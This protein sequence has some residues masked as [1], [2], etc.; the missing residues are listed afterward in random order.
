[1]KICIITCYNQPDYVRAKTLRA[2]AALIDDVEVIITKNTHTG[3]LRYI[4][5]LWKVVKVRF[6]DNPDVYLLTFRGYEMLLPVRLISLGKSFIYDEFV[7]PIEWVVLERRQVEAKQQSSELYAK[8]VALVSGFIVFVVSSGAFKFFYKGLTSSADVILAD[9]DSHA[10]A[11][12]KITGTAP[13]KNVGLYVGTDESTFVQPSE[14]R[15]PNKHFTV[16][17]YGNMLPLHGLQYVIDAAEIMSH[18]PIKFVLVGGNAK[19]AGDVKRAKSKGANIEY[20]TWVEFDQLP[21]LMRQADVCLAGPFGDTFQAQYVVTGKTYQYLSMARP[22]IIGS[23]EEAHNFND[24]K[25]VL[26]V[27]QASTRELIKTLKWALKNQDQLPLIG[28]AGQELYDEKF[29][30]PVLAKHLEACLLRLDGT[31]LRAST[32][33]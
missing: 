6:T 23:N 26:I 20:H 32:N 30:V 5:V 2:A 16:F 1:M 7:N 24:K 18:D 3:L 9:T 25:N 13:S 31:K 4:E 22:T 12:A 21:K 14:N 27:P 11:S 29:A 15:A 28:K 8:L 33:K 17:Y 10:K 19:V